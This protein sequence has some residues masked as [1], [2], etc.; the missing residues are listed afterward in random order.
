MKG[1]SHK[2][3]RKLGEKK[4]SNCVKKGGGIL[5]QESKEVRTKKESNCLKKGGGIF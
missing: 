4:D 3:Q 1:Y 2:C 5:T